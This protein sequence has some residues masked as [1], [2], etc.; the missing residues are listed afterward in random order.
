M[1]L[2]RSLS[3]TWF[4]IQPRESIRANAIR[5]VQQYD[6]RAADALQMAAALEWCEGSPG[7]RIFLT[8]DARLRD[9]AQLIGF[10]V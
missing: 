10:D 5:L 2:A 8:L 9:S 7:N 1:R 6:L 3:E 4:T